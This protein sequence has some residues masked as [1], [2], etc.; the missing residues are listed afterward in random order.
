MPVIIEVELLAGR[1]HAHVW[2][3]AQF[4]MAGPEWPPSPWRLLRALAS[5]WF[6]APPADFTPEERDGLIEALGRSP[7]PEMW[8]PKTV[9]REVRYYQPLKLGREKPALHHD[10]F[11]V[12]AGGRFYFVFEAPLSAQHQKLL[13]ILLG[14]LRYF[15]RAES[16][17]TVRRVEV[18]EPPSGL[19]RVLP[20]D[21]AAGSSWSPRPVLCASQDR[22]FQAPDL[23]TS[24]PRGDAAS[25]GGTPV[26]LVDALLSDRKPLPDGTLRVE[27]AQPD[28]S[29][30]HEIPA[31]RA[32]RTLIP[33]ITDARSVGFRLCRRIP[34]PICDVVA[35]ARAYRE[36][37]VRIFATANP[38]IHSRSLTGREDDGSVSRGNRHIYYL[39]HPAGNGIEMATLVLVVPEGLSLTRPELDA[40]MAVER[41]C[42]RRN[43]RY[44][45]TVIPEMVNAEGLVPSRRWRSFTPFLAPRHHDV[46]RAETSSKE[47]LAACI[48]A[49]CG[50]APVHV[51]LISGPAGAWTRSMVRAH[52]YGLVVPGSQRKGNWRLT[53]RFAH[54]FVLEFSTP[55]ALPHAVGKDAHFGL[56]QFTPLY[57]GGTGKN[58]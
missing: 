32:P 41:I 30:A 9:F 19:V 12:P 13:D 51:A 46:G 11:A 5:A 15:G 10:F 44:P 55:V 31:A 23:W 33:E 16:R 36:E 56:G 17:A 58:Q 49:S 6:A 52:E 26:H 1:F 45:I 18:S 2:G 39:P 29:V 48:E 27:Y 14:R 43:D 22:G 37:A 20:R 42:L 38:G 34:I 54:W 28:G 25:E 40:L 47:Q 8:L 3:E 53:R 50:A 4:A 35:V 57:N 21:R 24:R 7:A